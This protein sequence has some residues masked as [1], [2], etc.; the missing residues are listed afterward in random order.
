MGITCREL[1]DFIH[2]FLDFMVRMSIIAK[3][4]LNKRQRSFTT[5]YSTRFKKCATSQHEGGT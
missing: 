2:I 3:L 4:S 1:S 5:K